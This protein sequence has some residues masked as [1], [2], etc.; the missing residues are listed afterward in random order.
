MDQ[1]EFETT[2]ETGGLLM[3]VIRNLSSCDTNEKRDKEKAKLENEIR[4]RE[5]RLDELVSKHELDLSKVMQLF[6]TISEMITS[7]RGRIENVKGNLQDCK[8]KLKCKKE[9]LKNLWVDGLECKYI[10]QQFDEVCL[11]NLSEDIIQ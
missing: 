5:Q 2:E 8:K 10:L 11:D 4:S 1:R 6:G 9:E 7:N 3:S